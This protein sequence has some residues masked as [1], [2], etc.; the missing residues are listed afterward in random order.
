MSPSGFSRT[1]MP[2]WCR[3]RDPLLA[4]PDFV[5]KA[6]AGRADEINT[7]IACNQACLDHVFERKIASCLV[8]PRAGHETELR[9]TADGRPAQ[10]RG[11]RRGPGRARVR[12]GA[13]R[14]GHR[15]DLFDSAAEVGGQFNLARRVPGKEEFDGNAALLPPTPAG[16]GRE[17]PARRAR[18]RPAAARWPL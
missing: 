2:T 14:T 8:N 15:V 13:G 9:F 18:R 1:A 4:D 16:H 11:R 6:A 12:H 3:W 5:N 10:V 17:R 7:C